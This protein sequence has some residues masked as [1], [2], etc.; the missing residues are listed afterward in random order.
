MSY[1]S[2]MNPYE[3]ERLLFHM[4]A[5]AASAEND[6]VRGFSASIIKQARR[7]G[8]WPSKKQLPL[9]RSLV[10]DLFVSPKG[11]EQEGDFDLIES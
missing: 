5:V 9:M 1:P 8:W 10:S 7:K 4:P 11:N 2:G 3:V 6:F